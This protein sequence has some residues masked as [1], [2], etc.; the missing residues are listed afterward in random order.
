MILCSAGIDVIP[1][2]GGLRRR[3]KGGK[4]WERRKSEWEEKDGREG[5]VSG[6]R[7]NSAYVTTVQPTKT[8]EYKVCISKL[9]KLGG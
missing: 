6:R 3:E 2:S 4:G 9:N 1:P 8:K 7:I 5:R